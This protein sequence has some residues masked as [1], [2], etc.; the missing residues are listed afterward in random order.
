LPRFL[1]KNNLTLS[2]TC[3]ESITTIIRMGSL[4]QKKVIKEKIWRAELFHPNHG[5]RLANKEGISLGSVN[6]QF[7]PCRSKHEL[8]KHLTSVL[9]G[10]KLNLDYGRQF[11]QVPNDLT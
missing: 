5:L 4:R 6:Q 10:M 11:I 1:R 8:R 2:F 7:G 9:R 3:S